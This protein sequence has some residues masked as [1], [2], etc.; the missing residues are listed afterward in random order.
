MPVCT[1]KKLILSF[2]LTFAG[3]NTVFSQ[4]D[5]QFSQYM[6]HNSAFNPAAV[7]EGEMI[8]ATGQYRL[9]WLG[10]PNAGQTLAFSLNSPL[11]IGNSRNGIGLF[12]M[13]DKFGQFSNQTAHLQYAYKKQLYSGTLSVG[14]DI[15]FVSIG[16]HGGDSIHKMPIGDPNYF[17]YSSDPEIPKT[18]VAGT[19]FD[20]NV[21]VYYS[22]PDYYAGLSYTHLNSPTVLWGDNSEFKEKGTLFF[23]GGYRYVLPDPKYVLRPSTLLKTDFSSLQLDVSSILEYD[24]KYW[25]GISYRIQDAVVF[26]AGINLASGLSIGYSYDLLTSQ[27]S[28]VSWG[29]HEIMMTYSFEYVFGKKSGKYKSIRIL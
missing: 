18:N 9:Q 17:D 20:M 19:S 16:F 4:F 12:F 23:T 26:F 11:K 2:L 28:S 25:G 5:A 15:G 29:S 1:M 3:I 24:N 13:D 10:M 27:I 14:A 8:Q 6:F 22:T 7:G 21:G